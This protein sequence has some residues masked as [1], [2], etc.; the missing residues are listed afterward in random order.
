MLPKLL[1]RLLLLFILVSP[2]SISA[3]TIDATIH[4]AWSDG[5]GWVNWSL[6]NGN[7]SV[8]DATLTGYIWSAYFGWIILSPQKRRSS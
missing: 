1:P 2:F 3:A 5:G 6:P 8:T 7:V 4:Y